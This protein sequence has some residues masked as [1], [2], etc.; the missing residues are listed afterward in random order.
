L[1][2]LRGK[3]VA[4]VRGGGRGDLLC[5]V[6]VETPVKLDERQKTLL[7]QFKASLDSGGAK[8]SPKESSWFQGVKNFFDSLKN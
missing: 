5:K 8:H 6:L 2:R 7:R 1:F 4:P 3:G